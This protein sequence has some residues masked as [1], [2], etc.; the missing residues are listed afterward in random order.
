MLKFLCWNITGFNINKITDFVDSYDIVGLVETWTNDE[1]LINLPGYKSFHLCATKKKG[2]KKG[3]RSGGII[4]YYK[5]NLQ[6]GI[7][8]VIKRNYGLWIR[9]DKQFFNL[10]FDLYLAVVYIKPYY[11]NSNNEELFENLKHDIAKYSEKGKIFLSG[12]FNS[13]TSDSPDYIEND[14]SFI[15]TDNNIL[16]DNYTCDKQIKRKNRDTIMNLHGKALLE[17]CV[18]AK[19]RILNGRFLGD[20]F[21]SFTYYDARGGCSVVDY[22]IVSEDI[23]HCI[24]YFNVLPPIETSGHCRIRTAININDIIH[25]SEN[26]YENME[27]WPGNFCWDANCKENYTNALT[28]DVN[29]TKLSNFMANVDT[30]E[31]TDVNLMTKQLTDIII[32]TATSTVQFKINKNNTRNRRRKQEWFNGDCQK[33]RSEIRNIGKRVQKNPLNHDLK[34]SYF[35]AVKEYKLLNKK[36]KRAIFQNLYDQFNEL[37]DDNPKVF[38]KLIDRI[39]YVDKRTENPI[40]INDWLK[41][42]KNL[43]TENP[44]E[45]KDFSFKPDTY[46]DILNSPINCKEV[47]CAIKQLNNSK[48]AG[49]DLINNEFLKYGSSTLV[50]PI[51]KI[52]NKVLDSGIFPEQWNISTVS[53]LHKNGSIYD[54]N[55]YRGI[56]IGSCLGKLFTKILKTRISKYLESNNLLD[57]NQ[58]GF[59]SDYRTTDQIFI[60]KTL[61]NKYLHKLKKPINVCF[62]DFCKAFDSVWREAMFYKLNNLGVTGNIF[63]IIKNMYSNTYFCIK[64]NSFLSTPVRST[65]GVKQGDSLS[66]TL[67][68]IF[69]NDIGNCFNN[70]DRCKPV[71]LGE[72]KLSHLLFADDLVLISETQEGLQH[73]INQLDVYCNTWKLDINVHKT[74]VMIFSK[75]KRDYSKYD[76]VTNNKKI[77]IVEKYKYLGI[78]F[79]FNGNLKHAAEDLYNKALK[80]FFS[81]K[82][83]FNNFCDIPIKT[84]LKIFDSIVR[85]IVTY[86]SEIWLS[87]YNIN[88]LNFD[89]LPMEKLHHKMLK[90]ILGISRQASNLASRTECNRNPVMIFALTQMFKYYLRLKN[91]DNQRILHSAYRTDQDLYDN[92]SVCWFSTLDKIC[93]KVN[94]DVSQ[95]TNIELFKSNVTEFCLTQTSKHLQRIK[96]GKIESKLEVYSKISSIGEVPFYLK[97]PFPKEVRSKITKLRISD[98]R[99]NIERGRYSRPKTP[100]EN[101]LCKFCPLVETE[102]HFLLTCKKYELLRKKYLRITDYEIYNIEDSLCTLLNPKTMGECNNLYKYIRDAL[103]LRD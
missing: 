47:K 66:P 97:T 81:L 26:E 56:S 101:R 48:S 53:I 64:K 94:L 85:P 8:L 87:D 24:S 63:N 61:L 40:N 54:C 74:K 37:S 99:L 60:L 35:R 52:F 71:S 91:L 27:F 95:C 22:M 68:N 62:V 45:P 80:A 50:L 86:N 14:S 43:L 57:D 89:T 93:K 29:V 31:I 103:N 76:F 42:F 84:S 21:G 32:D 18:E 77:E 100:R 7:K 46:V 25:N 19:L 58:A 33:M 2:I 82:S 15:H 98:H 16:P 30:G 36:T 44:T 90:N 34:I 4:I 78:T 73:C 11:P 3:R 12:D 17:T 75:G 23:F 51:V 65:K 5:T 6:N 67:F 20:S 96:D 38:W 59:R 83:K 88:L 92:N 70:S 13:R 28:S 55:N 49:I 79:F 72:H 9:L 1:S 10:D 39:K 102:A 41:H 69:I